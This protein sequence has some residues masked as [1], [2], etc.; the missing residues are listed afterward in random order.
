MSSVLAPGR[1]L[2]YWRAFEAVSTHQ[3][4]KDLFADVPKLRVGPVW[5]RSHPK[6]SGRRCFA[7]FN[8]TARLRRRALRRWDDLCGKYGS[9]SAA[10]EH[11]YQGKRGKAAHADKLALEYDGLSTLTEQFRDAEL[12]RYCA[13]VAIDHVWKGASR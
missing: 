1:I 7:R 8:A 3:Q 10:L 9:A 11:L 13:R 4:R 12:L 2:N 6:R 5:S